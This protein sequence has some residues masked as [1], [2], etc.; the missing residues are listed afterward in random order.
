M[1]LP[2]FAHIPLG[3]SRG[4][5]IRDGYSR[6]WG[7][8]FG[9]LKQKILGD[10]LYIEAV[11][12]AQGRTVQA[13]ESRMN[14]YLLLKFFVDQLSMGHIVEYGSFRGGSA[15][16][17]AKVCSVLHP[18]MQVYALDTFQGMPEADTNIDAHRQGD[19][20]NVNFEELQDF[21]DSSGLNNL[22]LVRGLFQ[23]TAVNCL[24]NIGKIRLVHIDCDIKSA[25]QYAY[26]SSM[27]YMVNGGYIV[28]DDP[29]YSSCLG[30]TEVVEDIIIRRDKLNSE[31]IYPHFVFRSGLG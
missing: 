8:Q 23:H 1:Q 12:L 3:L 27:P 6:G 9:D 14:I 22:H 31:Q 17:M 2:V 26:E 19:F 10:P 30:A 7:L 16:F 18:G 20:S 5:N 4:R 29:L 28:L 15:I 13:E 21:I 24:K 25:V 11:G